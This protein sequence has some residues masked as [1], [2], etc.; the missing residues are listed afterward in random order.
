MAVIEVVP[1]VSVY[2]RVDDQR[3]HK[4]ADPDAQDIPDQGIPTRRCYIESVTGSRFSIE[5][6]FTH[7][8]RLPKDYNF[9]GC[10]M[11]LD[12]VQVRFNLLENSEP[13]F[14]ISTTTVFDST[15]EP[16]QNPNQCATRNFIFAGVSS[17]EDTNKERV[18][19]DRKIAETLGTI[20][21]HLW[22]GYY[23]GLTQKMSLKALHCE[24]TFQL[25]ENFS[26][27]KSIVNIQNADRII[28]NTQICRFAFHYRSRDAL[29]RA[30]IIPSSP[31][32]EQPDPEI[33]H[34]SPEEIRNLARK[35]VRMQQREIK[36]P[37]REVDGDNAGIPTSVR[38]LKIIKLADGNEAVDLTDE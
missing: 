18:A 17:V 27:N 8:H 22:Y 11:L 37:K 6:V 25:A 32:P 26:S 7:E 14:G 34:L 20:E 3:A 24:K 31:L 9:S 38:P 13:T 29:K 4:Y 21:L 36:V 12:G 15:L 30:F 35:M 23:I 10:K 19:R 5:I 1:G 16:C 28:H 2:V 33:G